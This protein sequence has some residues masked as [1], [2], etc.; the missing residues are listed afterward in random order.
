VD[1]SSFSNIVA[2]LLLREIRNMSTHTRSND[3]APRLAF[4]EMQ[5]HRP[6]TVRRAVEI[7]VHDVPPLFDARIENTVIGRLAGVGDEDV[8]FAEVLDDVLDILLDVG[9]VADLTFVGF[10]FDAVLFAQL[11]GVLF[12][13]FHAGGVG[14]CD[15]GAHFSAAAGSLSV[16]SIVSAVLE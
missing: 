16:Q 3:Q 2:C 1:T 10:G 11:F 9:V 7:R 13:A 14:Y 12:P 6:R 4:P 15:V 5:P 8:D